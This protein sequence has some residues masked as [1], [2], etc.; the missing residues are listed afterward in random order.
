MAPK[1]DTEILCDYTVEELV[2]WLEQFSSDC[3]IS[4]R[5]DC[6][7]GLVTLVVNDGMSTVELRL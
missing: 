6:F 7:H 2:K 1:E 3:E 5:M 4:Y